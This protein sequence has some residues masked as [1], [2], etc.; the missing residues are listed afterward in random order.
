M[1][2]ML[3]LTAKDC[4]VIYRERFGLKRFWRSA[5]ARRFGLLISLV[6]LVSCSDSERVR[7]LIVGFDAATWTT[8]RPL[9]QQGELPNL[10]ELVETGSSG[11]LATF[12]PT[13]S[14][15]IWTTIATGQSPSKH[16]IAFRVLQLEEGS[17]VHEML[18][19]LSSDERRVP[20]LWNLFS[21]KGIRSAFVG[22][23][24][25]W[26]A[27]E[28]AGYIVSDKL[29]DPNLQ[30]TV[31]PPELYGELK[32]AG[33]LDVGLPEE[34]EGNIKAVWSRF[35]AWRRGVEEGRI[36]WSGSAPH[37]TRYFDDLGEK[38]KAYQRIM[39]MDYRTAR[40]TH[41][42][43]DKDPTLDV[44]APYFW[45]SDI[46]QHMFWKY[47]DPDGFGLD[48]HELEIFA[49][50]VPAYY[51]FMDDVIGQLREHIGKRVPTVIVSDHGMESYFTDRYVNELFDVETLLEDLGWLVRART[52]VPDYARSI[53]YIKASSRQMRLINVPLAGR[54]PNGRIEPDAHAAMCAAL[55]ESLRVLRTVPTGRPLFSDVR[56]L[57]EGENSYNT[58]SFVHYVFE[59]A[60]LAVNI[61]DGIAV[62][63]SLPLNGKVVPLSRWNRWRPSISG[64]HHK[65]PPGIFVFHGTPFR[66]EFRMEGARVHDITPT[67]LAMF[68]L[69]V[70]KDLDGRILEE[71]FREGFLRDNPISFVETYGP[72]S[73]PVRSDGAIPSLDE[74]LVEQL[75]AIGYIR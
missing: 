23:W 62:A 8:L 33:V 66:R 70:A 20:A 10:S 46:C 30:Q 73:V 5:F 15:A 26:P 35:K 13:A 61:N 53:A 39:T 68:R 48:P 65:A 22:W 2:G 37:A 42:L 3:S 18:A 60:D 59:Q 71:T 25:T 34:Q 44:V 16:G 24:S 50:L 12:I 55:A 47:W 45:Y 75:R 40:I 63:D 32:E 56:V 31:Y 64:Q 52:K 51:Q 54:E 27:E 19:A 14:P 1:S 21:E 4:H 58:G 9:L 7:L 72:R 69:P 11:S 49:P 28:I 17:G 29:H 36:K 67:I 43:I 38:L 41:Y 74:E 6:T 57:E